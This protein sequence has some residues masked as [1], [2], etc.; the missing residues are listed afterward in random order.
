MSIKDEFTVA[1]RS[2]IRSNS[3]SRLIAICMNIR[4]H[5]VTTFD[6]PDFIGYRGEAEI[7]AF[8]HNH[9]ESKYIPLIWDYC[10]GNSLHKTHS[11][12]VKYDTYG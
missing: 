2:C 5:R 3:K 8:V 4:T 6:H 11:I 10:R 7:T 12:T 9:F 1:A